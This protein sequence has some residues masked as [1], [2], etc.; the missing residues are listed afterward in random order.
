MNRPAIYTYLVAAWIFLAAVAAQV[1][2]AGLVVVARQISWELHIGFGH[3]VGLPL[4]P[5][6]VAMYVAKM[7]ASIKRLTWALFAVFFL[8][9]EVVI[10]MREALPYV[11]ALHPVLAL[12]D[13]AI[14]WTLIKHASAVLRAPLPVTKEP[15]QV[16]VNPSK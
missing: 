13:F 11:S 7:P 14:A 3:L 4:L 2:L 15:I 10:F 6:L 9:A 16:A 8:Q 1:F 5:M 12:L